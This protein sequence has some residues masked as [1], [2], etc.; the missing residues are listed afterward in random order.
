MRIYSSV[1]FA[2]FVVLIILNTAVL[3]PAQ[4]SQSR[5]VYHAQHNLFNDSYN[6]QN[7]LHFNQD[8]S[9][10]IHDGYPKASTETEEG[11]SF[12]FKIGDE[13]GEPQFTDFKD[14]LTYTKFFAGGLGWFVLKEKMDIIKWDISNEQKKIKDYLCILATTEFEGRKYKAWF[15]P[16]IPAQYG[17]YRLRGLPGLILEAKSEDGKIDWQFVGFESNTT[18]SVKLLPSNDGELLE[19]LDELVQL[20]LNYKL[21]KES[22]STS[23]VKVSIGR[24]PVDAYIE[25]EK[26]DIY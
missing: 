19:G 20:M 16:D 13:E 15:T 26:F 25:K 24:K 8:Y 18:D 17:P 6:G 5:V 7:T 2:L 3:L 23:N 9:L 4:L 12:F 1:K 21:K 14:S 11:G 22:Q 10:Y